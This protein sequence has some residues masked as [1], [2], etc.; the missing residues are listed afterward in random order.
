MAENTAANRRKK[1]T[2]LWSQ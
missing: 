2:I 1:T